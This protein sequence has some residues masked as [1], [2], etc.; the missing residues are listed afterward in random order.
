MICIRNG[1]DRQPG[2]VNTLS[3]DIQSTFQSLDANSSQKYKWVT[4]SSHMHTPD[5]VKPD[6]TQD[7]QP[8]R[9][10]TIIRQSSRCRNDLQPHQPYFV[11]QL[12]IAL[13]FISPRL[14]NCK[15]KAHRLVRGYYER[16]AP[17]LRRRSSYLRRLALILY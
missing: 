1:T 8:N 3:I 5:C 9:R 14:I 4:N 2:K 13:R 6:E 11:E 10:A 7:S 16:V 12:P 15:K 17:R